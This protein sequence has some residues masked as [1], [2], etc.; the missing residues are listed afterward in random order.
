[1]KIGL[2]LEG[3][4]FRGLYTAGVLDYFLDQNWHFPYVIGVSMGTVNGVN[5][6]SKQKG[7]SIDIP[8]E[9]LFDS[10][11]F[12]YKNLITKG[13]LFGMDFIF[14]DIPRIHNVFDIK[15]FRASD[16]EFVITAMDVQFGGSKYFRKDELDDDEMLEVLKASC[17]LPFISKMVTFRGKKYLDGGLSDSVPVKKAFEDGV[18]KVIALV[19][20]E[21]GY[22]KEVKEPN[23][24]KVGSGNL[25][26]RGYPKVVEAINNRSVAYN[27]ELEYMEDM[28]EA[29]KVL[30]IYPKE[31][32]DMGRTERNRDKL[33]KCYK[34]GYNRGRELHHEITAFASIDS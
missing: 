18:D 11:Y 24:L 32:I 5:Y 1:M 3:G 33:W 16:Q 26:Y 6:I 27:K 22:R 19:T 30:V 28:V 34:D 8:S 21:K 17:S 20:R 29:G 7:R 10:R 25:R 31:E 14:G 13:S 2:V 12:S 15:T 23:L 9:F 4:G